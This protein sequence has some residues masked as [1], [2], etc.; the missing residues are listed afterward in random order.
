M[1]WDK[2]ILETGNGG[3][4]TI[5]GN[6]CA[7]FFN[8]ENEVYLRLFGGNIEQ[9][10]P[11]RRVAGTIDQS[12]WGNTLFL[13]D[14]KEEQFNSLTERTIQSVELSSKGLQKIE[15]AIA[16]DLQGLNVTFTVEIVSVDKVK[17]LWKYASD[18]VQYSMVYNKT[19]SVLDFDP[20]DFSM[21]DFN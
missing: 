6:D 9:D 15:Q 12:F 19:N 3:D 10:T 5:K 17:I 14:S 18:S 13:G 21:I 11:S 16:K 7:L 4:I 1:G 8:D 20:S 2:A